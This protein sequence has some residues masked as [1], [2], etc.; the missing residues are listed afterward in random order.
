MRSALYF[1][2]TEVRSPDIMRTALLTWDTLEFISP[3]DGYRPAYQDRQ[4]ARAAE[5]IARPRV[6]TGDEHT[7]VHELI[8]NLIQSGVPDSFKYSPHDG[9][10]ESDYEMWPQKLAPKT[11]ELLQR[12]GLTGGVL[13]NFDYP[14]SQATGLSL[15]AILADVLA[16]TTRAR[17]TDRGLAYAA[18]AN[19]PH[20]GRSA[21]EL[22]TVVPLTIET[23]ALKKVSLEKLV[24][25]RERESKDSSGDYRTLR[26]NYLA[27]VEK[28]AAAVSTV[29]AGSSDRQELDRVFPDTIGQDFRDLKRELGFAARETWLSKDV[30]TLAI[31]GARV[32]AALVAGGQLAL[33]QAI[34]GTGGAVLLGG[35]LQSGNKLAKA[36]YDILRKHPTAYLYQIGT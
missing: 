31:A 25:F 7:R 5:L 35:L 23:L 33:P 17:I 26:H 20:V 16:G 3:F 30:I 4:M 6:P 9:A 19:A 8:D 36:R 13:S 24:A 1:P 21:P 28:H 18:I 14:A 27:L 11:W 22:G 10:H 12:C 15:M 2:H 34:A 32:A 29:P